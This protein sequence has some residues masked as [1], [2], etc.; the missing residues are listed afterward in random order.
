MSSHHIIREDQEPALLVMDVRGA[1]FVH[2]QELLE[3]SPT[4]I[5][6]AQVLEE[7]L[8]WGIK[9]DIVIAQEE[10]ISSLATSL[11]DQSPVKLIPHNNKKDALSTALD[12]L[13][14]S[15]QKAVN[16]I[17][18]LPL[19]NFELF[20]SLDI[21]VFQEGRRWS[22]IRSGHY[23]KWFPAGR[24]VCVFPSNG[25]DEIKTSRDGVVVID[26]EKGFWVSE[27]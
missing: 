17:T 1:D 10:N 9:I 24:T 8:R 21:S 22:F 12:F 18:N 3:W 4:V 15:K 14:S 6:S 11:V 26:R 5:V 19:E 7:V 25:Q 23:E 27:F 16:I 20:S 13:I 2:V